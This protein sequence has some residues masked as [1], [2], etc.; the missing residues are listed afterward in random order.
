LSQTVAGD[1]AAP[2]S[3]SSRAI[4][5]EARMIAVRTTQSVVHGMVIGPGR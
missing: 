3:S 5:I 1:S 2:D 4:A